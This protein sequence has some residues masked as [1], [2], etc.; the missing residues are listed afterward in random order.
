MHPNLRPSLTRLPRSSTVQVASDVIAPTAGRLL[1]S[2]ARSSRTER[3]LPSVAMVSSH[4][5]SQRLYGGERSPRCARNYKPVAGSVADCLWCTC[6]AR[7]VD[8]VWLERASSSSSSAARPRCC[9]T[10]P[11]TEPRRSARAQRQVELE[12]L[13]PARSLSRHPLFQVKS[14]PAAA[15][16]APA[17][18]ASRSSAYGFRGRAWPLRPPSCR[19]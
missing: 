19:S 7:G 16:N 11:A 9:I 13:N 3:G 10:L 17:S 1:C 15:D 6:G 4:E 18:E 14:A 12:V 2:W 8:D 5:S